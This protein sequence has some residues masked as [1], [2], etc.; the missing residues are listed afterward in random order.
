MAIV[1]L[2]FTRSVELPGA[3]MVTGDYAEYDNINFVLTAYPSLGDM[4]VLRW[5]LSEITSML[6]LGWVTSGATTPAPLPGPVTAPSFSYFGV[7]KLVTGEMASVLSAKSH[8]PTF[9]AILSATVT[10]SAT[11]VIYGSVTGRTWDIVATLTP[12]G[13]GLGASATPTT[14]VSYNYYKAN[15]TVINGT[16]A[17]VSVAMG[18]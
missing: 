18:S 5:P 10:P 15:V 4:V 8:Y 9:E 1:K 11:V 12:S 13:S 7:D 16:L 17:S 2:L 6:A 14:P 3:S